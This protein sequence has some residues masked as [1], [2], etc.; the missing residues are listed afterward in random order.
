MRR[1]LASGMHDC[2]RASL[3]HPIDMISASM[4]RHARNER[5]LAGPLRLT[6]DGVLKIEFV[7]DDDVIESSGVFTE[8]L[9]DD[10]CDEIDDS[11]FD[12]QEL[13]SLLRGELAHRCR[14]LGGYRAYLRLRALTTSG[15]SFASF[16]AHPA[17]QSRHRYSSQLG[18]FYT[19]LKSRDT[20]PL[21]QRPAEAFREY[22][23]QQYVAAHHAQLGFEA[24]EGPFEHGPDFRLRRR[25]EWHVVEVE[26]L[27]SSYFDHGHHRDPRWKDCRYL[28]ALEN[29]LSEKQ[30]RN[31]P[32][33]IC[34]DRAHFDGWCR[35]AMAKYAE[36][37]K[38][39]TRGIAIEHQ[40][41]D[42]AAVFREL[43]LE[44][45]SSREKDMAMCPSCEAC[46]YF[47]DG[48]MG[49]ADPYFL[50][51]AAR[52]VQFTQGRLSFCEFVKF[53]DMAE[54]WEPTGIVLRQRQRLRS[55]PE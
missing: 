15:R 19:E 11:D 45:C 23:A 27:A 1:M 54:V 52:F 22:W 42:I 47:G 50:E 49:S 14:R 39:E 2:E 4:R 33:V 32:E 9:L 28:I 17:Y 25:R 48:E 46:P 30:A 31:A 24:L 34:I 38:P 29:D 36:A 7:D 40:L 55:W 10:L 44:T 43:V 35:S 13:E 8:Y 20:R 21:E 18:C 6:T 26:T 53:F 12:D 41:R 16:V 51:V 37:K 5:K 3:S